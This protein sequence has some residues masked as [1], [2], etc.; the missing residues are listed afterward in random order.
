MGVF[1]LSGERS[2]L[3]V[4]RDQNSD[5]H[6]TDPFI[7]RVHLCIRSI[8]HD[9][10]SVEVLG[11]NGA[12]I[13]GEKVNKGSRCHIRVGDRIRIGEHSIIWT[14][15]S[16]PAENIRIPMTQALYEPPPSVEIDA[17][18]PRRVPEKPSV[19]LSAGPALTMAVPIL[20]GAGRTV[21]VLSSVF[22]AIWAAVNVMG[23]TRRQKAE[24][25]R[26]RSTYI[27]YLEACEETVKARTKEASEAL[28][29]IYPQ[30]GGYLKENGGCMIWATPPAGDTA[31]EVRAGIGRIPNPV[32]ISVPK[33][34]FAG[35]DDSLKDLP[36]ELGR[37]Y[38]SIPD[39]PVLVR[40]AK[41]SLSVFW[42][43]TEDDRQALAAF[44]LQAAV[45]Y[46]P[47]SFKI[48]LSLAGELMRYYMWTSLLPH[49]PADDATQA[50]IVTGDLSEAYAHA[51][52]GRAVI[53]AIARSEGIPAGTACS[54]NGPENDIRCDMLSPEMCFSFASQLARAGSETEG[55]IPE[56]VPFGRLLGLPPGADARNLSGSVLSAYRE[57]DTTASLY[58][59]IGLGPGGAKVI[60]D[61]H[62]KADGPHGL[63]AGTTGSGKSEL[64]TTIILSLASRYPPDKL[65]FFLVDYKGGGMSNL[66]EGLPH[67]VG[68]ISNLS[69]IDA[70]RAMKALKSENLRRQKIFA[71]SGVN[72][73]NDYTRLYDAKAAPDPLPHILIIVDEFAELRRE[74]PDLMD[75]LI[76]V[77][78]IG[79]SLGMHLIL[80][81]Q[82]PAGVVDERIRSNSGFRI[83]LR[84]VERSDSVDII[85]RPDAASIKEC[86][87][88]ILAGNSTGTAEFQSGYAMSV[89]GNAGE[90]PRVYEDLL[91]E[92]EIGGEYA[93][94]DNAGTWFDLVMRAIGDA[95]ETAGIRHGSSLFL[96][97]LPQEISD[98]EAYAI[99]DD[100]AS[101][102]YVR[103]FY[104]PEEM[105]NVLITGR[106][107]SG[108]SELINT[109]LRRIKGRYA[110]YI[111]DFGGGKLKK[112]EKCSWC[113]GYITDDAVSDILRM[114]IFVSDELTRRRKSGGGTGIVL[115]LDDLN[116]IRNAAPSSAE[117]ITRILMLGRSVGI[118]V[119]ASA[120]A[121][122]PEREE[123]LFD[124][125]LFLAGS[126]IYR[127]ASFFRVSAAEIPEIPGYAG[128]G[129]GMLSGSVLE[130][131]AVRDGKEPEPGGTDAPKYPHLPDDPT[132]EHLL[133][134]SAETDI[135]PAGYEILTGRVFGLPLGSV[136]C[137]LIGGKPYKGRHTF[138]F[139]VSVTAA[140]I[141]RKYVDAKSYLS[142]IAACRDMEDGGIVS[143]GSFSELL[144]DF[145]SV[146]RSTAE[147]DEMAGF[148]E[149][150][151]MWDG[152]GPLVMAVMEN[153]AG[154]RHFGRKIYD[155][156]AVH[157]Y[158][159]HFGGSIDENRNFDFSYMPFSDMQKSHAR[160]IATVMKFDEKQF[161]GNIKIPVAFD[162]DNSQ[163]Q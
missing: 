20:L 60:L 82:K 85:G 112:L 35:V 10:A 144:D 130:F 44:I 94:G 52:Q 143:V 95:A 135:F 124:T 88:C 4:G 149:N 42:L 125:C 45:K 1:Y 80:A 66:F 8:R 154:S 120:P 37:R 55:G 65:A 64:L 63:I 47:H 83:A 62:E 108:K 158:V 81:T 49:V 127:E 140:L 133:E 74:E 115:V 134:A 101:Q 27:S 58:A 33:E 16:E 162:V 77:S 106:S 123:R 32:R 78:Q 155:A 142:F 136:R 163:I 90:R 161:F 59:P 73:I 118:T 21:A 38:E 86:G 138:L 40:L 79:R 61:I 13:R 89:A 105:G 109:L 18:P 84:L 51:A 72:S 102:R 160:G 29:R 156:A 137:I 15:G 91:F 22:A 157:P 122:V 19:L 150:S 11:T 30:V 152:H 70:R 148:F 6:L 23:R 50:L 28:A 57:S 111:I 76:S 96:P 31:V 104:S 132:L 98:S 131:Q 151:P 68:S 159:I 7:S 87:R 128:R 117:Y 107:G 9:V 48:A 2:P 114:A 5:L 12:V 92:Q 54:V 113:G 97:P 56:K 25:R 17:P 3:L 139:N 153:D 46:P 126:D 69:R 119:L 116:G 100:P 24:E 26:R 39:C 93:P 129:V 103:A 146:S 14:G 53:L 147:E 145:Y 43:D 110:V 99:Y 141:G 121:P 34:R 67:L 75:S 36:A 41:G 71:A